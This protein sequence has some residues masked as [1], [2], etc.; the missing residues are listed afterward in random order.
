MNTPSNEPQRTGTAQFD[1]TTAKT[2]VLGLDMKTAGLLCYTPICLINLISSL[3]FIKTEPA[4]NRFLRF[5]AMQ[6]LML[7]GACLVVNIAVAIFTAVLSAIPIIGLLAI[8][9]NLAGFIVVVVFLW[10]TISGMIDAYK[11][12]MTEIP[13]IGE[14]AAQRI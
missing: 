7:M 10:K 11:G 4:S 5:H 2:Q 3:V 12:N 9:L 13:Y 1:L 14:M 6:S 8:P